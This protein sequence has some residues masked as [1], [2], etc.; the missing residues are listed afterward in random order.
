MNYFL[1]NY[2][3]YVFAIRYSMTRVSYQSKKKNAQC[4]RGIKSKVSVI[5]VI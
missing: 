2:L 4:D 1:M 5:K 3:N